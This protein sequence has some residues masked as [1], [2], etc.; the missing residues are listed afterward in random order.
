MSAPHA[1]APGR[2]LVVG[3]LHGELDL[4]EAILRFVAFKPDRDILW[5]VGDLVDRGP[6][7][8]ETLLAFVGPARRPGFHALM[9]NHEALLL[10]NLTESPDASSPYV[11]WSGRAQ[12]I[13][14]SNGGGWSEDCRETLLPLVDDLLALPLCTVL[15]ARDG[16]RV[17]L[18]HAE[19]GLSGSWEELERAR[20]TA[21][22]Y[23][24]DE[25]SRAAS[26]A[27]WGRRRIR[28]ALKEMYADLETLPEHVSKQRAQAR[29]TK[30]IDLV[31]AGHTILYDGRPIRW[32]NQLWIETGAFLYRE[33]GRL[34]VIDI[35][36]NCYW[37]AWY[38]DPAWPGSITL[39]RSE[40]L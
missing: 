14:V 40:P 34:T 13:H 33:G 15:Q 1:S 6:R 26:T 8:L 30:G 16:R 36:A 29:I 5:S 18:V 35:D 9:G 37:Q 4:L 27:L 32:G 12:R 10:A 31:V 25:C 21:R 22:D 11:G 24:D 23:L 20:V 38:E 39:S 7:S 3:D 28:H 17:G 2:Q 19:V